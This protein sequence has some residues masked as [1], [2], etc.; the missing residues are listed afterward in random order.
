MS[1]AL[2]SPGCVVSDGE[3][4]CAIGNV[5]YSA[6]N[7]ARVGRGPVP[8]LRPSWTFLPTRRPTRRPTAVCLFVARYCW[9]RLLDW[10]MSV[11][12]PSGESAGVAAPGAGT[13]AMSA[14]RRRMC[15]RKEVINSAEEGAAPV[16]GV[17]SVPPS[18]EVW[19]RDWRSVSLEEGSMPVRGGVG[20]ARGAATGG[21][22]VCCHC[23]RA[24]WGLG[25][26]QNQHYI[27][28]RCVD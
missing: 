16:V 18:P 19:P 7:R 13:T 4:V 17:G 11:F 3:G 14:V 2:T 25:G 23:W 21:A 1:A 26:S 22:V 12:A 28:S 5:G 27:G 15:S 6:R 24:V 8:F 10:A 20:E 9:M